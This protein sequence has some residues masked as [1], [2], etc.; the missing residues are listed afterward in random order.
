MRKIA[1]VSTLVLG[2]S[3]TADASG[4]RR[5]GD[6][7]SLAHSLEEATERLHHHVSE[8][9]C[10]CSERHD[11]AIRRFAELRRQARRFHNKLEDRGHHGGG[12]ER[13]FRRLNRSY[14]RSEALL[15]SMHAGRTTRRKFLR[16][17][18]LMDR[19]RQR[20]YHS[21]RYRRADRR[22][23]NVYVHDHLERYRR[24]GHADTTAEC[25]D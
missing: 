22:G 14:A 4:R 23:V 8:R 3:A 17:E 2:L 13:A 6:L 15:D 9:S 5:T 10:S 11:R 18:R 20:V 7:Q 21:S 24:H 1:L 16:V 19:L 25:F 12:A